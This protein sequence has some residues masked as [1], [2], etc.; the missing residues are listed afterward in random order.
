MNTKSFFCIGL[1]SLIL[2]VFV[3][4]SFEYEKDKAYDVSRKTMELM[5]D[6]KF[7]NLQDLYSNDFKNSEDP[8]QRIEKFKSI[9]DA[10]G[11]IQEFSVVDSVNVE[12]A[13]N[14]EAT[15]QYN[16]KCENMNLTGYLSIIKDEG[17]YYISQIN[18]V[19]E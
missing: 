15:F 17:G 19:Q 13:V 7:E 1:V 5:K 2:F 12:V 14:D 9:F 8:Q 3:S 11:K 16:V 18:L 10:A 4:C 6:L